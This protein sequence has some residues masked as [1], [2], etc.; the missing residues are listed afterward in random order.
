MSMRTF[1]RRA[2]AVCFGVFLTAQSAGAALPASVESQPLPTLAPMLQRVTPAVVNIATIGRVRIEQNPLLNDPFFR[3]F[4]NI[5]NQPLE[6]QTQSL[7]SGVVIDAARGYVLTNNHVIDKA[8]HIRV[9]LSD[10]RRFDA[11]LIG[12]DPESDVAVIRIPAEKLTAL[13]LA[14]S[15]ALNVGD[16][17]VAIGNPFGL[18]QTVTSGIVS[19]LGRSGLG[20]EGYEDFIQTD[21]SI[22]P[23][24][25]GGPLVNLDGQVVGVN[26]QIATRGGDGSIGLGFAIPS[27]MARAVAESLISRGKIQRGYLGLTMSDLAPEAARLLAIEP[28]EGAVVQEVVAGSPAARAGL[29]P[30][31]VIVRFDRRPVQ[32]QNRLRNA[33]ALSPPGKTIEIDVIR[34]GK[35]RTVQ[36]ELGDRDAAARLATGETR[37]ERF[38]LVVRPLTPQLAQQLGV[39]GVEGVV[40]V[41]VEGS[42]PAAEANLRS[43]DIIVAADR[44]LVT[45]PEELAQVLEQPGASVVRLNVIR[46]GL[47]AYTDIR[48]R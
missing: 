12:A 14:D 33:I 35:S 26:N 11:E 21:A 48:A 47:K 37:L 29:R 45:T 36:V 38:G 24:N 20:I 5:P 41:E 23:G 43:G 34:E 18:G 44:R 15:D 39:R 22:N 46:E 3:R 2:G 25:S 10:G 40:A 28:G 9:M 30:G 19:A 31:D 17:V 16:F 6:R 4:F 42:S 7:G 27:N 1:L 13:P 32:G 8:E